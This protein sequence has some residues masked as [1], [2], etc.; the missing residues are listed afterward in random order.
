MINTHQEDL[1]DSVQIINDD[2]IQQT[3]C[4]K[5]ILKAKESGKIFFQST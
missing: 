3:L 5:K 4:N 1:N 2:K